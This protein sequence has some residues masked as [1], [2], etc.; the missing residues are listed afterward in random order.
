MVICNSLTIAMPWMGVSLSAPMD[1]ASMMPML[2]H[3]CISGKISTTL[4]DGTHVHSFCITLHRTTGRRAE[5]SHNG[6]LC[7]AHSSQQQAQR[8]RNMWGTNISH[9]REHSLHCLI[10]DGSGLTVGRRPSVDH[11]LGGVVGRRAPVGTLGQWFESHNAGQEEGI[12]AAKMVVKGQAELGRDWCTGSTVV[13]KA[14][15]AGLKQLAQQSMRSP[16]GWE[17]VC[18]KCNTHRV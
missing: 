1:F 3:L 2:S 6:H 15:T 5:V 4:M 14:F 9:R 8:G 10:K 11:W 16:W 17:H 7:H 13:A 18:R 12:A